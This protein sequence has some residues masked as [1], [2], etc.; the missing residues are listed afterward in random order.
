[1]ISNEIRESL[2]KVCKA[3]N[4]AAVDFMVIGGTAVGYYGYQRI[5]GSA[6]YINEIKTDLDFWYRPTTENFIALTSALEMLGVP[7]DKLQSIVFDPEKTFLK[8][9][10]KN[11]QTDFL[12]VMA[13]LESYKECKQNATKETIDGNEFYIISYRDLVK[14]KQALNRPIDKTDVAELTRRNSPKL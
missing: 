3:L 10:H 4:N 6:Q 9:P 14:N 7:L 13:G 12:P 11:F 8:I 5:S 1:M 2:Q